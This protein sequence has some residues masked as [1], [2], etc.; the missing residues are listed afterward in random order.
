MPYES[1]EACELSTWIQKL[2]VGLEIKTQNLHRKFRGNV[3]MTLQLIKKMPPEEK[4]ISIR[5]T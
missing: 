3:T 2:H 5:I 4:E 1:D